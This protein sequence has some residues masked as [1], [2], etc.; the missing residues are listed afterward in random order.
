MCLNK[1]YPLGLEKA[2]FL[3]S[4]ILTDGHGR[5]AAME[6]GANDQ[7][8]A[9]AR[10]AGGE[11]AGDG[12]SIFSFRSDIAPAVQFNLQ[13]LK[14]LVVLDMQET[15]GE[16]NKVR[17]QGKFAPGHGN[18]FR[19]P[20]R[21]IGR[22][23]FHLDAVNFIHAGFLTCKSRRKNFPSPFAPFLMGGRRAQDLRP[24]GPVR[25]IR[26]LPLHGFGQNLELVRFFRALP[27]GRAHAIGAGIAAA[28]H[29]HGLVPRRNHAAFIDQAGHGPV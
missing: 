1:Y 3:L 10:V 4:Q 16:Q 19:K 28:D 26:L 25:V 21:S 22:L 17:V 24:M 9:D 12:R 27:N 18:H 11:Y 13:I 23:P 14:Q 29:H 2:R 8:C 15:H 6:N 5:L 20:R 7:G